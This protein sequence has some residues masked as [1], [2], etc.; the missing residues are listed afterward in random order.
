MRHLFLAALLCAALLGLSGSCQRQA[1]LQ[2][3][4]GEWGGAHIGLIASDTGAVIEYDCAHG[5]ISE[6]IRVDADGRFEVRG[7]HVREHGGPIREGETL[8]GFPARYSGRVEGRRMRLTVILTE[9]GE[10]V[11]TFDL[12]RGAPAQVLKCL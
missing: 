2:G 12:E 9:T 7:V 1:T 3:V 8:P 4:T 11:G 10:K 6:A 5:S